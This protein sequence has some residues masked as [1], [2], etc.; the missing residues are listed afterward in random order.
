[1][2]KVSERVHVMKKN[3][4]KLHKEGFSI[5]EIAVQFNLNGVTVYRH[6]QEIADENNVHR[7]DLLKVVRSPSGE[8]AWR[9]EEKQ[10]RV[11]VNEL[12]KG[13]D[14]ATN[15]IAELIEKID[16]TLE[17]EKQWA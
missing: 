5:S 1:M 16:E 11:D 14:E 7:D 13:F 2:A 3:F 8:R 10:V 12:H 15:A 9:M 4:M 17:V 6:L